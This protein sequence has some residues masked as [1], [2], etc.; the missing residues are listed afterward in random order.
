VH[1][2]KKRLRERESKRSWPEENKE[3]EVKESCGLIESEKR[4]VNKVEQVEIT[5]R[6]AIVIYGRPNQRICYAYCPGA[7]YFI[8]FDFS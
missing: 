6:G 8:Y 2:E 1:C 7:F 5:K 4:M 3:R